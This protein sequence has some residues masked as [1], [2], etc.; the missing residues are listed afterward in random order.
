M[1]GHPS[2]LRERGAAGSGCSWRSAL[3]GLLVVRAVQRRVLRMGRDM[4]MHAKIGRIR[5]CL[6][7]AGMLA[8]VAVVGHGCSSDDEPYYYYYGYGDYYYPTS[9]A[10]TDPYYADAW[11]GP[12]T[13]VLSGQLKT[14]AANTNTLP[15][16][17]LRNLALGQ[18]VCPGHV[19]VTTQS[20]TL[21]CNVGG[22]TSVPTSTT[23]EFTGCELNDGGKLDGS[24]QVTASQT[25][26]DSNC[27]AG[28]SLAVSY[29]STTTNLVYTAPDGSRIAIPMLTRTGSYTRP[30][31]SPPATVSVTSQ[32][33]IERL[34]AKGT[35]LA[36]TQLSGSQTL[37]LLP[38]TQGFSADGSLM[39]ND[40]VGMHLSTVTGTG[41]TRTESCCYPTAGSLDV[42]RSGAADEIWTF[43]PNCGDV[44]VNGRRI[45]PQ[46]CF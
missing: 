7:A 12:S 19:M 5:S 44:T 21:A 18:G 1:A 28:T 38:G 16:T 24:V 13:A 4:L 22:G 25:L 17:A 46:A 27:D 6:Q 32:G 33:Q 45:T 10:Y 29:T 39:L 14:V 40:S 9:Y 35:A 15:A 31:G 34:D 11:Y 2:L 8:L 36:N 43:G 3:V 26:S 37:T 41:L 42:A 20:T 23:T 30:L